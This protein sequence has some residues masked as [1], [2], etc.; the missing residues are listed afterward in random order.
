MLQKLCSFWFPFY[1]FNNKDDEKH[2]FWEQNQWPG[3]SYL[4]KEE[5][6]HQ[7]LASMPND[8]W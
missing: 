6:Q 8:P 3:V 5:G 2:Q 4:H 1:G 7:G